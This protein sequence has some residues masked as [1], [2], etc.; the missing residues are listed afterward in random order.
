VDIPVS[1]PAAAKKSRSLKKKDKKK[2]RAGRPRLRRLLSREE[3]MSLLPFKSYVTVWSMMCRGEF[4]M[5]HTIGGK[6]CWYADEIAEYQAGLP[7]VKL[8]SDNPGA[9]K[10]TKSK[11]GNRR[12]GRRD[13]EQTRSP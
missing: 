3:L 4:P 5:S 7:L 2:K 13:H 6:V 12:G 9:V 11:R 8:K 10:I 1:V